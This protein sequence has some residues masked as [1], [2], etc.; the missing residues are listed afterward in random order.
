M[1]HALN[2]Q[3]QQLL[4]RWSEALRSQAFRSRNVTLHSLSTHL[5]LAIERSLQRLIQSLFR[6]G[7]LDP[8]ACVHDQQHGCWL[9][10]ADQSGLRFEYLRQ[11]RMNSWD[12][13]GAINFHEVGKPAVEITF[14]SQLLTLVRDRLNPVPAQP[15]IQRL[16]EELDDSLSNDTLCLGFHRQWTRQLIEGIEPQYNGNLLAWL[17]RGDAVANPTALLEQWGTL[18]HPWHPNYKTKLGLSV[19]QVIDFSPEFEARIPLMLCALHRQFAHVEAME[20]TGDYSRWWQTCF[21]EAAGQ[22]NNELQRQGL[23]PADYLPLPV[24]PW[25]AAHQLPLTFANE[26]SD[27]LLVLT[28]VVEFTALPTMSFRTVLPEAHPDAPMVKLPVALSLT[29]A[30]RTV[31]PRA[32]RMGPRIS[33]LLQTIIDQEPQIRA[34]LDIL[35]ERIGV[36]FSPPIAN[37]ERSRQAAVLYRDNPQSRLQPGEL[38]IPVGSLFAL[39]AAGQPLLRHWIALAEG[40]DDAQAMLT[41]LRKYLA[42]T[43]QGLLGMYLRYGIAFEAHQQNSFMIMNADGQPDRLLVRDFGDIRIERQVLHARGLSIELHDPIMTLYDDAGHVRNKLLH[44]VFMC[45]LGELILLCARYWEVPASTLWSEL[46]SQIAL[47]FAAQRPQIE[48][49]RWDTERRAVLEEDWP[50]KSLLRMRLLD[51]HV[52]VVGRLKNPLLGCSGDH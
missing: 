6:E 23:N 7:L 47:C 8:Q 29:S 32:V 12:L 19:A 43:V 39:D 52:D 10:F 44:A 22:L 48:P 15:V 24:H 34:V 35:P 30:Q 51:S 33:H 9:P 38:A 40:R 21:P 5:N 2:D 25:Q 16:N 27:R 45:H 18:G 11:G 4:A 13:R 28:N 31:S 42:I 17:S 3:N 50:A 46:A 20:G 1:E 14:P 49:Q 41:F 26:I 37:D 36:H